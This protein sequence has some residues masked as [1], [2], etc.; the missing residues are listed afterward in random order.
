MRIGIVAPPWLPVPPPAYGGTEAVIDLLARTWR[1]MG[2]DVVLCTTGDS[3]CDVERVATYD[4]AQTELM[5]AILPEFNHVT[6]AYEALDDCDVVHDH[7]LL[8]PILA[9]ATAAAATWT[10]GDRL[11]IVSTSHG[12][13]ADDLV[14]IFRS[15]ARRASIIAISAD[16]ASRAQGIPVRRVIH[17]GVDPDCYPVGTGG[18]DYL[19][20]LGRMSPTKG[21]HR[22]IDI[23]RR[24]GH[25]LVL[26]AKCRELAEKRYFDDVV[27]P[28]LGADIDYV[29]EVAGVDKLELLA[30]ARALLNP[31]CWPEPFGLVMVEA[32]ACGTPVLASREGSA[33]E[34]V[35]HG[36][37]GFLGDDDD[38]LV[39]CIDRIDEI[40][41]DT[42]RAAV[43]GYF[44]ATRMA[45][46]YVD[47]FEKVLEAR[48]DLTEPSS[49]GKQFVSF[50]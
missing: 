4:R 15:I 7:T 6:F 30:G 46:E 43:D 28:R 18:G 23:A 24:G 8:G 42:C 12:P 19:L 5:G 48:V 17:H 21:V 44:S 38:D 9:P 2:H 26:A 13:F 49:T 47:V 27:R 40:D 10:D 34:I 25:R 35:D 20:F 41:R 36:R 31:I 16:Q 50:R 3:T 45:S 32:L 39:R 1:A 33:A 37:T 14:P 29:G 22:A 11:P